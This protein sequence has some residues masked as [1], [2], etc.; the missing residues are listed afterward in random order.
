MQRLKAAILLGGVYK[1]WHLG[2]KRLVM[3][4]IKEGGFVVDWY[5]QRRKFVV[6]NDDFKPVLLSDKSNSAT[7]LSPAFPLRIPALAEIG[8][9]NSH[10][11]D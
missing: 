9:R 6:H 5:G 11:T 4:I 1:H 2:R 7:R 3:T 8:F 10:A